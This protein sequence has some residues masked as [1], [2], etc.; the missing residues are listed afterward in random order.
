M[1]ILKHC[2]KK[3]EQDSRRW[4][5][6]PFSWINGINI[7]KMSVLSKIKL[8]NNLIKT[9]VAFR[10]L[11]KAILNFIWKHKKLQITKEIFKNREKF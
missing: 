10:E 7:V 8:Q 9:P 1:K 2:Y 4:K 3:I 5:D 6:L 11:D